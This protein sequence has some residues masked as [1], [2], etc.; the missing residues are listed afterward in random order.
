M[1]VTRR[2]E[3]MEEL[4]RSIR[5]ADEFC[6]RMRQITQPEWAARLAGLDRLQVDWQ[7]RLNRLSQP[8]LQIHAAFAQFN[9]AFARASAPLGKMLASIA[10]E[11]K[12]AE[13][14]EKAGWLPHA[15]MPFDALEDETLAPEAISDVVEQHCRENWAAIKAEFLES[16]AAC[17]VDV[18]ARATFAEALSAHEAGLYRLTSRGLFPEIERVARIE[19][20][21]GAMDRIASQ[22]TLRQVAGSLTLG[23]MAVSGA[24]GMALY[25]R[26]QD[27]LYAHLTTEADLARIVASPVPNRHAA[28]HGYSAYGTFKASL[29]AL[30]IAEFIFR[31]ISALKSRMR[32]QPRGETA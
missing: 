13:R 4:S 6:E 21:E 10:E 14:L 12:K 29:N 8:F 17:D 32:S 20:H 1:S 26:L 16:V 22:Q 2:A 3:V 11:A 27:H 7:E 25:H 28:V 5:V 19:I 15:S 30:I 24:H 23:E 18:E 9:E 31:T